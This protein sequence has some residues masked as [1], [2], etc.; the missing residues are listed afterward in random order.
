MSKTVIKTEIHEAVVA[1][2]DELKEDNI[3]LHAANRR[4]SADVANLCVALAQET[5]V[6]RI[7]MCEANQDKRA[8]FF[9][10]IA[11]GISF[12]LLA[13]IAYIAVWRP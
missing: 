13:V 3:A 9:C 8:S 12:T 5:K 2:R 6:R 4:L 10:G 1:E 7:A 11:L